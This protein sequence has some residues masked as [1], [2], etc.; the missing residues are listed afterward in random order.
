MSDSRFRWLLVLYIITLLAAA[1][2]G[3]VPG[4]YSQALADAYADE[5]LPLLLADTTVMLAVALP[6]LVAF[7]VGLIGLFCF[8]RRARALSLYV[9]IAGL[10]VYLISGPTLQ[11]PIENLLVELLTLL[12]GAILASSYW[13]P[14]ASR[15]ETNQE[16][17][18]ASQGP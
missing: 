6:L 13:S 18:L 1:G 11:S 3:F 9:T 4:G 16:K 12:W 15:F 5:P 10:G 2:V 8:W 17:K 14:I 7:V